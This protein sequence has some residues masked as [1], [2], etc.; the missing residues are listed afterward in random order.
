MR[1]ILNPGGCS[2]YLLP[3]SQGQ[4]FA[5]IHPARK[6]SGSLYDDYCKKGKVDV[7]VSAN[8]E[9]S[10]FICFPD[11]DSCDAHSCTGDFESVLTEDLTEVVLTL[12][13]PESEPNPAA[14]WEINISEVNNNMT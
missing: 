9:E 13:V 1:L 10:S 14:V 5:I 8:G 3:I 12:C 11:P 6:Q 2:E 7:T 4:R